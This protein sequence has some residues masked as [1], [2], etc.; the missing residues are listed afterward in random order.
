MYEQFNKEVEPNVFTIEDDVGEIDACFKMRFPH[1]RIRGKNVTLEQAME[2]VAKT[3]QFFMWHDYHGSW[4]HNRDC[5]ETLK[6]LKR[7]AIC[8]IIYLADFLVFRQL[9]YTISVRSYFIFRSK[10]CRIYAACGVSQ[11]PNFFGV[12][13][14]EK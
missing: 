7:H 11:T 1:T 9:Y 3:E 2:I 14:E 10:K 4:Q 6:K 13:R 5:K 12:R 8:V